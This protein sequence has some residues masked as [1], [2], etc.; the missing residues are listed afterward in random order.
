MS[1]RGRRRP[2]ARLSRIPGPAAWGSGKGRRRGQALVE[3]ALS[4]PILIV[5]VAG[6]LELGRGY[7]F[8]VETSDAARDAA[9]FVAGKTATTNGPGLAA[10]CSLVVADLA[11]VTANVSC[12]TQVNHAPPFVAG[13]DYI[14]PVAGQAVVVGYCGSTFNCTG[15]IPT[16]YQSEVA[17]YVYY[18]F[19]DLN[20]LAGVITF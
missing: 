3:L 8:A 7:A 6:V 9:R 13:T 14:K 11:A 18:G 2:I 5:L 20:I 16:L 10:M 4:L 17:V 19:T 1:E 15:S 12:P